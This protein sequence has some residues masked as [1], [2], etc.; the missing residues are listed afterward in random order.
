MLLLAAKIGTKKQEV[1]KPKL[2]EGD[3]K[4]LQKQLT[5]ES[6]GYP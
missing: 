2:E 3:I 6:S 5:G 4:P 1:L